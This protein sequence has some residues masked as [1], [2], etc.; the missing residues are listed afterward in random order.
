MS[1]INSFPSLNG[2]EATRDTLHYYA[3]AMGV[4]ARAH[5]KLD[6]KWWHV[7]LKVQPEGLVTEKMPLPE[8]GIFYLIMDFFKHAVILN[9][10]KGEAREISMRE[11]LTA[12]EFGDEILSA[13]EELGL[14]G[15]YDRERFADDA[16]REYDPSM[17]EKYFTVLVEVDRIFK[18]HRSRLQGELSPVQLWPHN[19]DLA[20]D[21][22][23][24]RMIESGE[25]DNIEILPAQ[26]N[27]GFAPGDSSHQGPYFYSNP[28]PFEK[29]VLVDN[30]LP[31]G[32]RWFTESWQGTIFPYDKLVGDPNYEERLLGYARAVY[33]IA[34]P[35]LN[36]VK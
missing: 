21:W 20:L 6:P 31:K 33:E 28:W 8:G 3:K 26:L 5:A 34:S 9:T 27:V 30:S 22:Y 36:S 18:E 15:E 7:S 13:V 24:T 12:S 35:T 4:V 1:S 23:G 11:G 2:W 19:F 17:A 14:V 10:D 25:G 16:P 32:A 29:D